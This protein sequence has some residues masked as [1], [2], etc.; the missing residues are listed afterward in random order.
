MTSADRLSSRLDVRNVR[1]LKISRT[2]GHVR[3][4]PSCMSSDTSDSSDKVRV[5]VERK[6][7]FRHALASGVGCH[8]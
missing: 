3:T 8:V 1:D 5:T 4:R 6:P 7:T 2:F